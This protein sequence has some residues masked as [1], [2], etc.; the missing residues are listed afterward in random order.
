MDVATPEL[1]FNLPKLTPLLQER[2][3]HYA[4]QLLKC[5]QK[6][7]TEFGQSILQYMLK[8]NEIHYKNKHYPTGDRI[9]FKSGGQYFYHCHRE[10]TITDEHGHFHCYLRKQRIPETLSPI[11]IPKNP[12]KPEQQMT[13]V[14][15]ISLNRLGQPIRLF[16]VN[17]WVTREVA[18]SAKHAQYLSTSFKID[19]QKTSRWKVIDTWVEGLVQIFVPQIVWLQN[20]RDHKISLLQQTKS[21]KKNIFED[22]T[23][24]EISSIDIDL[25]KQ[26]DWIINS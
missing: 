19:I 23:I 25:I 13:H 11:Y 6:I 15:A 12:I 22:K 21:T 24:E 18:Y 10:N 7:Q 20:L 2:F 8:N 5:Q 16:T 4:E 1:V 26:V 14:I 3:S 17:Y 9:D